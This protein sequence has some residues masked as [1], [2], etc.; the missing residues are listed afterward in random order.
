[1]KKNAVV[2]AMVLPLGLACLGFSALADSVPM[3]PQTPAFFLIESCGAPRFYPGSEFP[4]AV[5]SAATTDGVL[6]LNYDFS[7]G[8]HYVA[9]RY[10]FPEPCV[11]KSVSLDY[12]HGVDVRLTVRVIDSTG[13]NH[14]RTTGILS[15]A[16]E[17]AEFDLGGGGHWGGKNDGILHQP[18]VGVDILADNVTPDLPGGGVGELLVKNVAFSAGA[19][20]KQPKPF[21]EPLKD[22]SLDEALERARTSRD[23]LK[24]LVPQLEK[25]GV[26]AKSRATLAVLDN[27]IPWVEKDLSRGL[28]NRALR[29]VHEM[30]NL[31]ERGVNRAEGVL[32]GTVRD[33]PVPRYRTGKVDIT[34]AQVI[35]D[36]VW[37][38]GRQDRG[39]VFFNGF[40]HFG[41]IMKDLAKMPD[42][43]CNFMQI[44]FGPWDVFPSEGRVNADWT[45]R[46][47]SGLA[48]R[49]AKSNVSVCLLLS[50]HYFP[51]WAKE[52]GPRDC[53]C[54]TGYCPFD[55][56]SQAVLERY[57]RFVIPRIKDKVA[58]HSVCLSN[59]P[60]LLSC[61]NCPRLRKAWPRWLAERHVTIEN[62]NAALGTAY[63]DF[64]AVPT[65]EGRMNGDYSPV[66]AEYVRFNRE[67]FA[68][69]HKWMADIVHDIAPELPVHVKIQVAYV[70]WLD[71]VF[72]SIDPVAMSRFSQYSGNDALDFESDDGNVTWYH[73]WWNMQAGYDLQRSA[74]DIPIAN[75]ENH[76]HRDRSHKVYL[77]GEHTYGVLW[78]NALHGQNASA[79]WC[80][81]RTYDKGSSDFNGL[82][83]ERPECLEAYAHCSL[84]LNRLAGTIAPLQNLRP[85]VLVFYSTEYLLAGGSGAFARAYRAANFLGQPL[86][87]V[88]EEMLVENAKAAAPVRPFDSGRVLVVPAVAKARL[89]PSVQ[90][91][92]RKLK[93]SGLTVVVAD[94]PQ[95]SEIFETLLAKRGAWCLPD[96]PAARD[97]TTGRLPFGVETRGY[98][99][100]G[101]SYLSILNHMVRPVRLKLEKPGVN[102]LTGEPVASDVTAMPMVPLFVEMP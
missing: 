63:A 81:E 91:A 68:R 102:L 55:K 51:K 22:V 37:P 1:M 30:A 93:A 72:Y 27:F 50:P 9:A 94:S 43:G 40:G 97:A 36:R 8:G 15:A 95:E 18:L 3:T 86:G 99:Q 45:D 6:H 58:L 31:G 4:G 47:F 11:F 19:A 90:D 87:V 62:L 32:A 57:Y 42:L 98:R 96:C 59:E 44:E 83:L 64:D 34:H 74:A 49:A 75:T 23:R 70:N 88:T 24:A 12:S 76:F 69:W 101:K 28:T 73:Q 61:G 66:F 39:P 80:W 16:W 52:K 14:M 38:D 53:N 65:P 71:K 67:A 60:A 85:T 77:P 5:G 2:T 17:H 89:L 26:G 100:D 20:K 25:K 54:Y 41:M 29:E 56:S 92:I 13:Q 35:G 78:Q 48:D 79:F 84:D 33:H 82:I 21:S 7:K 10:R 46:M